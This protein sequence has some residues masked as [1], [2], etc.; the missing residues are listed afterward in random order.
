MNI[1]KVTQ[2]LI[3]L[4]LLDN[5][6]EVDTP[7]IGTR[8]LLRMLNDLREEKVTGSKAQRWVGYIQG[9]LITKGVTSVNEMRKLINDSR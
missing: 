8:H 3:L 4:I 2:D 9:V 7:D 1:D 6:L 5:T